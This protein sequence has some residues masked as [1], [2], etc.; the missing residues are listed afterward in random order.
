[1]D[2]R[3]LACLEGEIAQV[4]ASWGAK[5]LLG[6][7]PS[8]LEILSYAHWC[9]MQQY[10]YQRYLLLHRVFCCPRPD[11]PPRAESQLRC[12][13]SGAA[14]LQIHGQFYEV[15]R[16]RNYRR[17]LYGMTSICA[18]HGALALASCLLMEPTPP[19][20]V[21]RVSRSVRC[22][23]VTVQGPWRTEPSVCQVILDVAPFA[24]S[25]LLMIVMRARTKSSR[26]RMIS[27]EKFELPQDTGVGVDFSNLFDE[28]VD[29]VLWLNPKSLNWVSWGLTDGSE[30]TLAQWA[31]A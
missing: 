31:C 9:I 17:Y 1:M 4:Q 5:S 10:A 11:S 24:V 16:L 19:A 7:Q 20:A 15:P 22:R 27:P 28:W 25:S 18:M 13:S 21:I 12:I 30:R 8:L 3:R 29:T 26:V 2:E 23:C 6:G 14:L